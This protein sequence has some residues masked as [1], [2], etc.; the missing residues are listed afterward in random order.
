MC[1]VA[2]Q[3]AQWSYPY[4]TNRSTAA[5]LFRFASVA[6][7]KTPVRTC[8]SRILAKIF[9]ISGCTS[10]VLQNHT[11]KKPMLNLEAAIA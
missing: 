7:R 8:V 6:L 2:F 10:V 5:S 1:Q 11:H 9:L 4:V 3:A